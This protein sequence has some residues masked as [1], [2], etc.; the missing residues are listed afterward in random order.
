MATVAMPKESRKLWYCPKMCPT[1][2]CYG[3]TTL[4]TTVLRQ[5]N[6]TCHLRSYSKRPLAIK[7]TTL[8]LRW[9]NLTHFFLSQFQLICHKFSVTF[10]WRLFP[11]KLNDTLWHDHWHHHHHPPEALAA[12][13]LGHNC[14]LARPP[15][16]VK[17]LIRIGT[18]VH[19]LSDSVTIK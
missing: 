13:G 1:T 15:V 8:W 4:Q 9:W 12:P 3:S 6:K 7:Y 10:R 5:A 14:Q 11:L 16:L 19:E 2:Q 18:L 17:G